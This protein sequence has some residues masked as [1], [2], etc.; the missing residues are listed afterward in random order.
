MKIKIPLDLGESLKAQCHLTVKVQPKQEIELLTIC[1]HNDEFPQIFVSST[2]TLVEVGCMYTISI[3][4][5]NQK[6]QNL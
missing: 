4:Q 1:E 2:L 6:N 5:R 3:N